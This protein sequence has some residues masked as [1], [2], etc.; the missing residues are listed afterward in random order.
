MI[1]DSLNEFCDATALSTAATGLALIGNVIPLST[2]LRDIA[3]GG[4]PLFVV[5]SVDTAVTS[6]GAATVEFQVVSDAAAAI[7]VDGTATAHAKS[8]AIAKAT[9]VAGYQIVL[10]LPP[11][12]YEAYLGIL[13]NVGVAALTA[14]KINAFITD[15]PQLNKSYPDSL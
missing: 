7:A 9:L 2:T 1:L 12:D 15:V 5:I 4:R 3:S 11:G 10:V 13:Q 6:A 14:G 8:A